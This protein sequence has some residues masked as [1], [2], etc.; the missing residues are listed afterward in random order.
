MSNIE[1]QSNN[2][3]E[4]CKEDMKIIKNPLSKEESDSIFDDKPNDPINQLKM[5][6]DLVR[7]QSM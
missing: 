7:K 4:I 5:I 3:M 6:T 1:A 2:L